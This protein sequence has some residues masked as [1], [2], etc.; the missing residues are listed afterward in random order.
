MEEERIWAQE[1]EGERDEFRERLDAE[2]RLRENLDSERLQDIETLQEKVKELEEQLLKRDTVVQQCRNKLL[3]KERA[4]KE[5]S[6]Q[7]DEKC[8]VY[9]ELIAVSEK[10]KKQVD[11]L[12]ASIKSRDDALT[13]LNNKHRSLLS[14]VIHLYLFIN[15]LL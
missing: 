7:L 9:D 13:D 1:L 6:G 12:R 8:R 11:Q 4:V 14:Q 15:C 3:E 5:K 2:T 10:R